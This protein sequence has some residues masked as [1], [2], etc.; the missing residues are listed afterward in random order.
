MSERP[1]V[2]IWQDLILSILSVNQYSLEKTYKS[3][4]ALR[5]TEL[6][7]PKNIASWSI[8]KIQDK[9]REGG[10]DR[11]TFMTHLFAERIAA[12]GNHISSHGLEE[13]ES[14]LL[15]GTNEDIENLLLPVKGIGPKVLKNFCL[16]KQVN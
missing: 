8:D 14:I 10:C 15:E 7:D 12:L 16:L 1:G 13:C 5:M 3:V 6:F 11:G 2:V 9:L 4:E